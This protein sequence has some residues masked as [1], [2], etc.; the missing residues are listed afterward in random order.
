MSEAIAFV[1]GFIATLI[2]WFITDG[3]A[4]S[5]YRRGYRQGYFDAA[6]AFGKFN[7]QEDTDND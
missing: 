1:S 2:L 6:Q 4:H 3:T 5:P 7:E